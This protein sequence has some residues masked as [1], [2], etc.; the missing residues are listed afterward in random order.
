MYRAWSESEWLT[1]I[2][3][4]KSIEK[5]NGWQRIIM[6]HQFGE[7]YLKYDDLPRIFREGKKY[8]IGMILLFAWW[9]EGMDNGYPNYRPSEDLGGEEKL[10]KAIKTIN[11][12]GGQVILYA[13]GH[14]ID[15]S[16]EYYK[17]EGYKYTAKDIDL[18]DYREHY[19]FSN[20]GTILKMGN[21]SFAAGCYGTKEWPEKIMEIE[22]R[23]L[24]LGSNGTFFDQLGCGFYL[25]FDNTHS[26]GNRIDTDPELRLPT[27]KKIQDSLDENQWF[28][29]EW[30]I[31]RMSPHV[32]FTH[33]CGCG[34]TY[35]P[36]AYPYLFRYTYPEIITSN[37]FI[38]DEKK[39]FEKHLNYAFVFGL[40]FD[41]SIYRCRATL[42]QA[43]RFGEYVSKLVQMR[44]KYIDHFVYGKFDLPDIV[45]PDGVWG[46]K[47]TFGGDAITT[48]WNDSD[49]DYEIP[50]GADKGRI[51]KHGEVGVFHV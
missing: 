41:V 39:G 24:S 21:K 40:I 1:P 33:G 6:K 15:I 44:K 18:N 2:K 29:T 35:T 26:H 34:M 7:I 32:D 49:S 45:L 14:I 20:S 47:Y 3:H 19:M 48:L 22:R 37:R 31:D 38:H 9:E 28:G 11:D 5:L 50:S 51:V 27:V 4:K 42:E 8:G 25:C 23:H 46:A 43:P 17:N 36:D 30:V 16:T 13:N 10:R 12:E